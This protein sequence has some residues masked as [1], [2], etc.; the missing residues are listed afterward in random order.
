MGGLLFPCD[1][2]IGFLLVIRRHRLADL[3]RLRIRAAILLVI[4]C[5]LVIPFAPNITARISGDDFDSARSRV[6]LAETAL[7]II[8]DN[9]WGGVGYNNYRFIVAD[10]ES[11]PGLNQY[12]V[13]EPVHNAYLIIAAEL[14]IPA[15]IVFCYILGSFLW[16]GLR[17]SRSSNKIS[18]LF[19]IGLVGGLSGAYLHGMFEWISLGD[20]Q[21][22]SVSLMGGLVIG[23][24]KN[25]R[26][27]VSVLP[28]GE[29]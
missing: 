10:Y 5:V 18:T 27:S 23:L 19:A 11:R 8:S 16:F 29:R 2:I 24:V 20:P 13:P 9:P 3:S 7:R 25:Q 4:G 15:A 28:V 12:R 6:S 22:L 1:G 14:G 26:N 21:F 17:V